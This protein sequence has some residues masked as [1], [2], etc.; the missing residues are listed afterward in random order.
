MAD[1]LNI[2]L[3]ASKLAFLASFGRE[4]YFE[5][6]TY[7]DAHKG[8]FKLVAIIKELYW[9]LVCLPFRTYLGTPI[10]G[11]RGQQRTGG[12]PPDYVNFILKQNKTYYSGC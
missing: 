4:D 10:V 3:C 12:V 1:N 7:S 11:T 8:I 6:E 2:A 9:L 5:L